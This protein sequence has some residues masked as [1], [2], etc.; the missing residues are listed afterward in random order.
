MKYRLLN[1]ILI[2]F[3]KLTD[4]TLTFSLIEESHRVYFENNFCLPLKETEIFI[5][6][7]IEST[8]QF[9][10]SE[11]LSKVLAFKFVV[12]K[13]RFEVEI[14]TDNVNTLNYNF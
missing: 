11:T 5:Y 14:N 10:A 3:F 13:S 8:L 4:N 1:R 9:K 7:D 6:R 12:G 2:D